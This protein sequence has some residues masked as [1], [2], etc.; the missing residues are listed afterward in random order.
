MPTVID[1]SF[2]E[3]AHSLYAHEAGFTVYR[4]LARPSGDGESI[5]GW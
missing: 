4:I 1:V 5:I 2:H 3:A